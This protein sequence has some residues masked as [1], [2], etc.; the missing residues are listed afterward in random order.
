VRTVVRVMGG[1]GA[2]GIAA[3]IVYWIL[4][5][6][7]AGTILLTSFGLMPLIV[8]AWMLLRGDAVDV[9]IARADDPNAEPSD[10]AG[11]IVGS[12]PSATLWPA[13]L[14]L[15]LVVAGAG[16]VYGLLLV[17]VGIAIVGVAILGLMRE[18]RA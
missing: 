6:E 4:T 10:G 14:V 9:S 1:F 17:P 16:L 2:F 12:F 15:G 13:F 3:A 8:V 11:E 18:S 5:Q 7:R